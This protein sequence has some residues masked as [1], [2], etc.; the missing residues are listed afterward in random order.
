MLEYTC[1]G[2]KLNRGFHTLKTTRD[3]CFKESILFSDNIQ[4]HA[5]VLG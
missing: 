3:L 1:T 2:G 5:F 4:R